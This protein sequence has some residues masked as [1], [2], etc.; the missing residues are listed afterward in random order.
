MAITNQI[1]L[2]K[3][4]YKESLEYLSKYED[5]TTM[6]L[7]NLKRYGTQIA[8][9]Q[10]YSGNFKTVLRNDGK[11]IG[12][13]ELVRI[14]N[15]LVHLESAE[16]CAPILVESCLEEKIPIK[17]II[18]DYN[19]TIFLQKEL[20]RR[21]IFKEI[22]SEGKEALYVFEFAKKSILKVPSEPKVVTRRLNE[23]DFIQ[24]HPCR[25]LLSQE[26]KIPFNLSEEESK[27]DF[28]ERCS[29]GTQWGTFVDGTLVSTAF[30]IGMTGE[31]L[32]T[33]GGVWTASEVRRRKMSQRTMITLMEDC[34][35]VFKLRKLVLFTDPIDEN[36]PGKLYQSLGFEKVGLFGMIFNQ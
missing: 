31:G 17:G 21:N 1:V 32:A 13:F 19:S 11:V 7:G 33:I 16:E 27:N 8:D 12:V 29:K 2:L 23:G 34:K 4:V 24:Y 26:L 15:I 5:T 10:P 30:L 28:S 3:D 6:L 9:D 20:V 18:G 35:N 14:G 36:G 22:E 25:I